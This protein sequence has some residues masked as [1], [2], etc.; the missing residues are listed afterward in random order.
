[1]APIHAYPSEPSER[2]DQAVTAFLQAAERGQQPDRLQWVA[3]YP[4]MAEGLEAFFADQD[5][6]NR[7][8][9]WLRQV[10]LAVSTARDP[11]Q[12]INPDVEPLAEPEP[13]PVGDYELLEVIARGGMGVVYRARQISLN[14]TVALKMLRGG[15]SASSAEL[16]RFRSE[17]EAA[18]HL[19]HPHIVPIHEV[20]EHHGQP[21]FSMKLIEGGNLAENLD[22]FHADQRAAAQLLVRVARAVHHAHLRGILHR[23]LKP[24]NILIDQRG[25]PHVTDFGLAKRVERDSNM[26]QSGAIVGTPSYMAPEQATGS[27]GLTTAADVYSL[28][29][30]LYAMLTGQPPFRAGTTLETLRQVLEQEPIRPSALNPR[31]QRDLETICLRCLEKQPQRRYA[32]PEA[33]ADDLERFVRGEPIQARPASLGERI[34][35]WARR[36]PAAAGLVG[37]SVAAVLGLAAAGLLYQ[38]QRNRT[39]E[40]ELEQELDRSR[41]T[42]SLRKQVQGLILQGQEA[43]RQH[44]PDDARVHLAS[45][46]GLIGSD[47]ALADFAAAIGRLLAE[48]DQRLRDQEARRRAGT[49]YREFVELRNRALFHGTLFTGVDLKAS[50]EASRQAAQ[51]ALD[52]FASHVDRQG[53]LVLVEPFTED[54]AKEI[55]SGYYELH[56]VLAEAVAQEGSAA[57]LRKAIQILERAAALGPLTRAYCLRLA[58]YWEQLEERAK[59]REERNRAPREPASALDDFLLGYDLQRE[60]QLGAAIAR[61]ESAVRREPGYFWARYFLAVCYLRLESTANLRAAKP[62]STANLR[63]AKTCLNACLGQ[64]P[65]FEWAYVLRGFVLGHLQEYEAAEDDFQKI[66]CLKSKDDLRY[67]ALVNR[68]AMRS[69]RKGWAVRAKADLEEAARLKPDQYQAHA[70]LA[71]LYEIQKQLDAAVGELGLAIRIAEPQVRGRR[72]EPGA[73]A[74]LYYNRAGLRWKGGDLDKALGDF[75]RSLGEEAAPKTHVA[76]GQLLYQKREYAEA[77]KAYDA[78]LAGK[79]NAHYWRAEALLAMKQYQLALHSLDLYLKDH[80]PKVRRDVLAHVYRVRGWT[81]AKLRDYPGAIDDYHRSLEQKPDKATYADRG[82]AYLVTKAT[83]MA[84]R[85]F[86]KVIRLD[87]NNGDAHN[88]LANVYFLLG[89]HREAVE[90]AQE[91]TRRGPEL[92]RN[93]LNAARVMALVVARFDQE[94]RVA[95]RDPAERA[96]YQDQAVKFLR[97][98]VKLT[99]HQEQKAFWQ[100]NVQSKPV[101]MVPLRDCR[102]LEQLVADFSLR[103]R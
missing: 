43:M 72:L 86:K 90:A 62:E 94:G 85:D 17:A 65:R 103:N 46:R 84:E 2:L 15:Q 41:R 96:G 99:P 66:L 83:G 48:N 49:D 61:F 91:A 5:R 98:A 18:A 63:V 55:A 12:T 69:R 21:Y 79:L 56:L 27:R 22:Q 36:R 77:V 59:A 95:G 29:A 10:A 82:W 19:D 1:M 23:D 81:R 30:I 28:G 25:E 38:E 87:R 75:D 53:K 6:V 40:K 80:D 50:R 45:A 54:Q 13:G 4:D 47:P 51:A 102:E 60:G 37:V 31:V 33:L 92:A 88:G 89:R 44:Q 57:K 7:W 16:Q 101:F 42:E 39:L 32:S 73:L 71:R 68:G 78:A 76:R 20:G 58:R 3:R 67:A 93:W 97:Q 74:L 34:L 8:T 11:D 35:R 24:A 70:N 100:E 14:R 64:Q 26:T 9:S 52:L